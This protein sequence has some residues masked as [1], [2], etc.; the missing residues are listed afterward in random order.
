MRDIAVISAIGLWSL[1]LLVFS[2]VTIRYRITRRFLVISWL[3][4]PIRWVRLS[5]IK[6]FGAQHVI[7]AE[8]W[9][10]SLRPGNRYLLIEKKSALFFRHLVITPRN[11]MV[12][13]AE[14]ERAAGWH[15]APGATSAPSLR[16][17]EA[18]AVHA[19]H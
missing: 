1:V 18:Q 5:H 2:V 6:A 15:P 8:H 19:S 3:G 12:F 4:L 10:N 16:P 13:K 7:W 14:L 17:G 11:H 9:A